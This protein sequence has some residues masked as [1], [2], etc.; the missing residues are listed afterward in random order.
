MREDIKR[1]EIRGKEGKGRKMK[2]R[3]NEMERG[4]RRSRIK[5]TV[6]KDE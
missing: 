2:R 5:K 4:K 1:E 6:R 3:G